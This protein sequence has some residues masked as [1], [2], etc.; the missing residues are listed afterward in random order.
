MKNKTERLL[1]PKHLENFKTVLD[2]QLSA[3]YE[4]VKSIDTYYQIY[5]RWDFE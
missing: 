5:K 2:N 4:K 1:R 3:N